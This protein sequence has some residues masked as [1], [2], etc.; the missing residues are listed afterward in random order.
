MSQEE[1]KMAL[2][3]KIKKGLKRK[4]IGEESSEGK[5]NFNPDQEIDN[6]NSQTTPTPTSD[7]NHYEQQEVFE[8]DNNEDNVNNNVKINQTKK[9]KLDEDIST[10]LQPTL[11]FNKGIF[12]P[13]CL[14]II[15]E[16]SY[17]LDLFKNHS[18]VSKEWR[19]YIMEDNYF[20]YELYQREFN[21][22]LNIP[23]SEVESYD[24]L[25]AFKT[26]YNFVYKYSVGASL[27][28]FL[29][30]QDRLMKKAYLS[31]D[32]QL[33]V[34]LLLS[35]NE[36]QELLKRHFQLQEKQV[37]LCRQT[38]LFLEK[39]H[40]LKESMSCSPV[41]ASIFLDKASVINM[42]ED[43][44]DSEEE[45][46]EET[47]KITIKNHSKLDNIIQQYERYIKSR[48]SIIVTNY[49][50]FDGNSKDRKDCSYEIVIFSIYGHYITFSID[51]LVEV[52]DDNYLDGGS[53]TIHTS[54]FGNNKKQFLLQILYN[55]EFSRTKQAF[56]HDLIKACMEQ[57]GICTKTITQQSFVYFLCKI[58]GDDI[59]ARFITKL[60]NSI[61]THYTDSKSEKLLRNRNGR[62]G[63]VELFNDEEEEEE[64][65]EET[66][67]DR[68]FVVD[69]VD[70]ERE[71]DEEG[72]IIR[73]V[74]D[75]AIEDEEEDELEEIPVN[76]D[77]ESIEE[78]GNFSDEE[79]L[80]AT[81]TSPTSNNSVL[82]DEE[83]INEDDPVIDLDDEE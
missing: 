23:V 17:P 80:T 42:I 29:V 25:E 46:G 71:D 60:Q 61:A 7:N 39:V 69:N 26:R 44:E 38:F 76:N 6:E 53:L 13:D 8:S 12:E 28:R 56:N 40:W 72:P 20:W 36:S 11:E 74:D 75:E 48:D 79:D 47:N 31:N 49:L 14:R 67:E 58:I 45:E 63:I 59:D 70:I 50:D 34:N 21:E 81:V 62:S 78:I 27:N 1:H 19:K 10:F 77:D 3:K 35:C 30:E 68:Q 22:N 32:I 55:G 52:I 4:V 64:D 9:I 2:L 83:V 41:L 57:L 16:F 37:S 43:D 51:I 15:F 33:S 18:L 65:E 24:F 73:I 82:L 5:E 66:E 54:F